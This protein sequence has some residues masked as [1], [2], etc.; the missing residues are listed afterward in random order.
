[1]RPAISFCRGDSFRSCRKS[2]ASRIVSAVISVMLLP[3]TL[4]KRASLRSRVP[5]HSSH[6]VW[7]M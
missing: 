5:P 1:M 7:D 2:C 6:T 3:P 4:T